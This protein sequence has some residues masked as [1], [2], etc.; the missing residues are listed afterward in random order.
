MPAV[1][2]EHIIVDVSLEDELA[3]LSIEDPTSWTGNVNFLV[4]DVLISV[5]RITQRSRI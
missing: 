1:P 3:K 4:D 2:T 5:D